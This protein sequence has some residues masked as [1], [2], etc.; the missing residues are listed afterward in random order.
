V[1]SSNETAGAKTMVRLNKAEH[2][3]LV[4]VAKSA[5]EMHSA[6]IISSLWD[7]DVASVK[8][9]KALRALFK[10]R[11]SWPWPCPSRPCRHARREVNSLNTNETAGAKTMVCLNKAEHAAL[12]AVAKSAV[13]LISA[14]SMGGF[15]DVDVAAVK[16]KK[17]LAALTK[18]K[19]G[20]K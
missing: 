10:V 7:Q 15:V 6:R 18:S 5:D 4:A 2:A 1:N 13:E 14:R 3:A 19:G 12:V 11:L 17:A 9:R 20:A 16:M 8:M